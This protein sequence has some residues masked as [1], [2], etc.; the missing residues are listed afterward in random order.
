MSSDNTELDAFNV[1]DWE[2][3]TNIPRKP[4]QKGT[5]HGWGQCDHRSFSLRSPSYLKNKVKEPS[6]S[7]VFRA[8]GLNTIELHDKSLLVHAMSCVPELIEYTQKYNHIF[9]EYFVVNF[10]LPTGASFV[11]LFGRVRH[12]DDCPESFNLCWNRFLDGDTEYR[13]SRF[14]CYS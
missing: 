11:M 14:V 7:P 1:P 4:I 5:T 9:K 13:T 2:C 12:E 3:N 6:R 8:L 10:Q